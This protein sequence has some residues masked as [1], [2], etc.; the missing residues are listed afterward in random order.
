MLKLKRKVIHSRCA[1]DRR[2]SRWLSEKD[3]VK[4]GWKLPGNAA[5]ALVAQQTVA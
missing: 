2:N 1:L 5:L 3:F 4:H